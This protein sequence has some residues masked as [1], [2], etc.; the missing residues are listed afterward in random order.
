MRGDHHSKHFIGLR[1]G[2]QIVGSCRGELES[3]SIITIISSSLGMGSEEIPTHQ[4]YVVDVGLTRPY[5]HCFVDEDTI[6][7]AG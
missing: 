2:Q 3:I 4:L 7:E 5:S 1:G 6:A